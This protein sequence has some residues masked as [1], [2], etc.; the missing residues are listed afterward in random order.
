MKNSARKTGFFIVALAFFA[1]T[2]AFSQDEATGL[3]VGRMKVTIMP[4]YDNPSVLVI[5]EG[6]FADRNAFP[7]EVTFTLPEEVTK[8]TD[9]CSLSPAGH[10]FCQL[11]E[12]KNGDGF[13]YLD[14]KLPY[15]DF[16][17]DYQYAPF[18]VKSNSK[19]EFS[20]DV[21]TTYDIQT[22][23]VHIQ[24]PYRAEGFGITPASSDK[25]EKNGFDYF[26]YTY[27]DVKA[28]SP[29]NFTVAYSKKDDKPSV[30]IKYSSMASNSMFHGRT[31]E[32]LLATGALALLLIVFLRRK[33]KKA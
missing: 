5:Q 26:K 17:I 6:K 25:Y 22:L 13:K 20:F 1:A 24:Q 15:S 18:K 7:R 10:H 21:D 29:K 33:K 28:G 3:K 14:V 2:P 27:K 8:L 9:V 4:E 12:I 19:R 16:F 32:I 30:D 11:F 31:G 23:E